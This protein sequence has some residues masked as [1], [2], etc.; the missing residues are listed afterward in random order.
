[1]WRAYLPK[2]V[3]VP[4]Q[5]LLLAI[6][7]SKHEGP[8]APCLQRGRETKLVGF[9]E[10]FG[11][12]L[13]VFFISS[14]MP[15]FHALP[16]LYG[17]IQSRD[18][19]SLATDYRVKS[20]ECGSAFFFSFCTI[21]FLEQNNP[22]RNPSTLRYFVWRSWEGQR[23]SLIQ[24]RLNPDYLSITLGQEHL[25]ERIL[26]LAIWIFLTWGFVIVAAFLLWLVPRSPRVDA[27]A[28]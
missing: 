8:V 1:M 2:L 28:S 26:S 11:A 10:K 5:K 20:S 21:K 25:T 17:D 22:G 16:Q 18:Q 3:D 12:F 15:V 14:T 24:S 23:L 19:W 6:P 27:Q 9:K 7:P 13:L 4:S